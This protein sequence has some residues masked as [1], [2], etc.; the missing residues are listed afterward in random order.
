MSC[1]E[2]YM[3]G[4]KL[5]TRPCIDTTPETLAT[6]N[7]IHSGQSKDGPSL[8]QKAASF[9][10]SAAKHVACGMPKATQ[11]QIDARFAVCQTCEFFDGHACTKCG[12]PIVREQAFISKLAWA[13]EKCPVDKWGPVE[14]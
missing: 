1:I 6:V 5:E 3:N 8:L 10:A 2:Q 11:E 14:S 7:D 4:D 9:A 13:N 12:C